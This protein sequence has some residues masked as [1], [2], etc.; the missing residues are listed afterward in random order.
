MDLVQIAKAKKNSLIV[1]DVNRNLGI[2]R[3]EFQTKQVAVN[4]QRQCQ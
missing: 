2:L 3:T 4:F 1:Y